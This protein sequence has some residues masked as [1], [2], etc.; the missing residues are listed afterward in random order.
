MTL[1]LRALTGIPMQTMV[2]ILSGAVTNT[3]GLG[4]AQQTFADLH[5][6]EG[7]PSIALGYAVAYPLGVAGVIGAFLLLKAVFRIN[8]ERETAALEAERDAG[9]RGVALVSIEVR[10]PAIFGRS[11]ADLHRLLTGRRFVVSRVLRA[12]SNAV[13]IAAAESA[14]GSGDRVL[15]AVA[16]GDREVV[17]TF[18]GAAVTMERKE[19]EALDKSLVA[20]RLL[21]TRQAINGRPLRRF[22]FRDTFGVNITRVNRA[23][24][25][26]VASPDF[27]LQ[28][29]DSVTVVGSEEAVRGVERFLGNQLERLNHPNLV[30]IFIGIALG[31]LLGSVPFS[32]PGT[33][34]PVRLGL[35]GGPLV[36]AILVS[37]FGARYRLVTY[38]TAS[39]NL[40]LRE[41]GICLFLACVGIGAGERFLPT[42]LHDGGW[43]WIGLGFLIT[44]VPVLLAGFAGRRFCKLNHHTLTG[45]LAGSMT[46]P[47]ALA[48]ANAAAGND[49]PS[50]GYATVYPL[51]MFLRVLAAQLLI[52]LA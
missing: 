27:A 29:G 44:V 4:A 11:I 47:P 37:I 38:T 36:V 7:D 12:H 35:A 46:D 28:V 51:T 26:L 25:E 43:R 20:R 31:V 50:V 6:G 19:W 39:A 15:A 18:L 40:M 23:G 45:L 8:A 49:A 3:P 24:V 16:Q 13:E 42:V 30:P 33:P 17:E 5:G 21:I 9:E 10:N 34:Q 14:L 41:V 2:G 48:F 32:L 1:L 52:L 22:N